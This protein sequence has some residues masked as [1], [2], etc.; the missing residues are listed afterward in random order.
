MQRL[1]PRTSEPQRHLTSILK[2]HSG[3]DRTGT[4][5]VRHQGGR[6]KR[7]Y[8]EIDFA[9]DKRDMQAK[10]VGIEYDPNRNCDIALVEYTDGERRYILHPK[11]LKVGDP[12]VAGERVDIKIGN[13]LPLGNMPLGVGVHNIELTPGAGGV[14]VR[15]AGNVAQVMAKEDPYVQLKLPS[16]EIRRFLAG[17]YATIG[18]IGNEGHKEEIIG[19]A[20]RKRRMGIHQPCEALH[21]IPDHILT[22]EERDEAV[23][24]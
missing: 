20:G 1:V 23:R 15:G 7:Y 10:V 21:R 5:S 12:I 4:I 9:R 3:R 11:D 14:M 18:M 16:G 19:T 8:R 6:H 22:E 24:E 2:K 13:A 17:C